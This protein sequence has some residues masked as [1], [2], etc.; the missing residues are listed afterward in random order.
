MAIAIATFKIMPVDPEQ[1]LDNITKEAEK[2]ITEFAGE[3]EHRVSREPIAFGLVAVKIIFVVDEKKG[4]LDPLQERIGQIEGV[5]SCE[6]ADWRRAI[7]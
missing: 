3:T 5:N 7:G 4:S 2:L 1:D 6:L